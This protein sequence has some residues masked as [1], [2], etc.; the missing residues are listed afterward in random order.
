MSYWV[1]VAAIARIDYLPIL[2]NGTEIDFDTAFG[3]ECLWD[4]DESVWD[5]ARNNEDDYLPMGS[6]GSLRKVVWTNPHKNHANQYAVSIFGDLRDVTSGQ[7]IIDWFKKKLS[8]M[9]VRQ[10][11]ISVDVECAGIT[12][13]TFDREAA[14]APDIEEDDD[15]DTED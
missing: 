14:E 15:D 13:W 12:T 2:N 3:K 10:A 8:K 4:S 11:T 1:H 7:W 6:E 9:W 5:D